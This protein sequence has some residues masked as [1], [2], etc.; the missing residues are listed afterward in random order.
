MFHDPMDSA[1]EHDSVHGDN[2]RPLNFGFD[3]GQ[4][5]QHGEVHTTAPP[6]FTL[7]S[8]YTTIPERAAATQTVQPTSPASN[9]NLLRIQTMRRSDV[10]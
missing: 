2:V 3:F 8:M 10:C 1:S 9:K 5:E 4:G 7:P 6:A